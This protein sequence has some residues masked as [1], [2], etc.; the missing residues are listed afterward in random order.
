MSPQE[1]DGIFVASLN[2]PE[3]ISVSNFSL[4]ID[5]A[6]MLDWLRRG[7]DFPGFV[8]HDLEAE[9]YSQDAASQLLSV[10]CNAKPFLETKLRPGFNSKYGVVSQFLV[11]FPL[12]ARVRASNGIVW[13][14]EI[15]LGYRAIRVDEPTKFQLTLDFK[16]VS[17]QV[18][19]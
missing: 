6:H 13:S 7:P 8:V 4:V 3:Q 11:K 19:A 16:I 9:L 2:A 15:D 5:H 10:H 18:E 17:H 12:S 14:L 1:H